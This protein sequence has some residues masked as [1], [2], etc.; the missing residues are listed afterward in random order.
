MT[1][2]HPYLPKHTFALLFAIAA[3]HSLSGCA[4]SRGA[5]ADRFG[6]PAPTVTVRPHEVDDILHNP[7]MGFADFHFGGANPPPPDEYPP[8]TVAYLRW[9]W[10]ELEPADGRYD[11]GLVDNALRRAQAEGKTLAFRIMPVYKS[12]TPRWLLE[13]GVDSVKVGGDRFPDHNNPLF[14][15]YHER[16][17]KAFGDRYGG[18]PGIDHVDIGSVGCWGEWN[19]ACCGA[20]RA[21]CNELFPTAP[22]RRRITDWY[23]RYFPGTPLVMLDGGPL[24]YAVSKGTGWRADCFGDYGMFR[25]TWNHMD[26]VYARKIRNPVIANAW[27][28]A[29]VQFEVCGVMQNWYDRGFDIDRILAKGLEWHVSVLNAKSSPVPPPWRSKV[30]AFLKRMGYRFVLRELSHG[31]RA[32]PGGSLRIRSLWENKGVAPVYRPWPLAYRLRS[33]DDRVVA[34]WESAADLRRWLPGTHEVDDTLPIP[35][36]V[37]PGTYSLDVAILTEDG[38]AAH[39]EL[40]IAGKRPDKWYRVSVVKIRD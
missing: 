10:A 40:A 11:F 22:N 21:R 17:V 37:P 35:V 32:R 6:V 28:T 18:R 1:V 38:A 8:Q 39:V 31:A 5:P 12:S 9:T 19:T 27:K 14:L 29:P 15:R 16:L 23:L 13:K 3:I 20:A 34:S 4:G 25:P 7:G 33:G 2:R 24:E 26:N 36:A 30:N